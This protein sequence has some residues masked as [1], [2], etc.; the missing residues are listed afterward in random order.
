MLI[1][2]TLREGAQAPG[3]YLGEQQSATLLAGLAAVGI[4]EVE[5][6]HSVA[7]PRLGAAPVARLLE[8]A[9][10]RAP[11]VRRTVWCR[12]TPADVTAAA[13]LQPDAVSF[14]V[15][16]SDAHLAQRLGVD[17]SW[18][19]AQIPRLGRLA[20]ER[21]VPY[22]SVGFEDA[23]RA[24]P[25]FLREA[26]RAAADA[27][28]DRVRIADTVGVADP[29]GVAQLVRAVRDAFPGD[30][31]VHVHNDFGMATASSLAA[32]RA[33]A[34]SADV[35]LLGLGERAG[36]APTEQVAAWLTVQEGAAYDLAQVRQLC[37]LLAGWLGRSVD[38]QAP[39]IGD[40][41]FTCESGLHVAGLTRSPDSYEPFAPELVGASRRLRLGRWSGRAA[42]AGLLGAAAPTDPQALLVATAHLRREAARRGRALDLDECLA[43]LGAA[44]STHP[45]GGPAGYEEHAA[46]AG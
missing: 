12:A 46:P 19:L 5:L 44:P 21:G 45:A 18:A 11:G 31:G 33:G 8:V 22:V 7:E 41:L 23:T 17:R 38:P 24:E 40:D 32:L 1:D 16:V 25:A 27:G 39:I 6:G 28:L 43:L 26:A 35:T 3:V 36:I 30:V 29:A 15:P 34:T 2:T 9:S 4:G 20:R 37:H 13:D 10:R 14:A 42:V